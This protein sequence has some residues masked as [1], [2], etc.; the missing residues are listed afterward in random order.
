MGH[1][2]LTRARAPSCLTEPGPKP[3]NLSSAS[4]SRNTR[5]SFSARRA[6]LAAKGRVGTRIAWRRSL[7]VGRHDIMVR[8]SSGAGTRPHGR[9]VPKHSTSPRHTLAAGLLRSSPCRQHICQVGAFLL[10][11]CAAR[12]IPRRAGRRGL[13]R[14]RGTTW[15]GSCPV[16]Q[17]AFAVAVASIRGPF[18]STIIIRVRL[19][20]LAHRRC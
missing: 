18:G 10:G 2:Q 6:A 20:A 1:D 12:V 7:A 16:T 8:R 3:P 4:M 14:R 19:L 5:C 17:G 9:S 11:T 13:C 15:G